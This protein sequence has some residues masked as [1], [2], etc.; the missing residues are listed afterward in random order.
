MKMVRVQV[1]SEKKNENLQNLKL[2]KNL[3]YLF[4]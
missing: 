3:G 2:D 4:V 1:S